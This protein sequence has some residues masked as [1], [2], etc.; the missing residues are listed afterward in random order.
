MHS[1]FF[2]T[3]EPLISM[4]YQYVSQRNVRAT[5]EIIQSATVYSATILDI[6]IDGVETTLYIVAYFSFGIWMQRCKHTWWNRLSG[7]SSW[8]SQTM[9]S[10][11][12]LSGVWHLTTLCCR[13]VNTKV[14]TRKTLL[15]MAEQCL[16]VM[17]TGLNW[18]ILGF[19]NRMLPLTFF[20]VCFC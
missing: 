16:N 9:L 2:R 8:I 17:W 1:V 15:H 12:V 14:V 13:F 4:Q 7:I 6:I 20:T 5:M 3:V 10:L 11:F 19:I 18:L